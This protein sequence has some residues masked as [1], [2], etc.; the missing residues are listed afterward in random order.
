ML[1]GSPSFSEMTKSL[2]GMF[3][4]TQTTVNLSQKTAE[5]IINP[6]VSVRVTP[7]TKD[8]IFESIGER[9]T[10]KT[11]KPSVAAINSLPPPARGARRVTPRGMNPEI[12]IQSVAKVTDNV[13]GI[14]LGFDDIRQYI[15]TANKA[16][17]DLLKIASPLHRIANRLFGKHRAFCQA[18]D[19][20]TDEYKGVRGRSLAEWVRKSSLVG[21]FYKPAVLIYRQGPGVDLENFL[22][23]KNPQLTGIKDLLVYVSCKENESVAD[24]ETL[25]RVFVVGKANSHG[26][27]FGGSSLMDLAILNQLLSVDVSSDT[28]ISRNSRFCTIQLSENLDT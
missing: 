2:L 25:D 9:T 12:V 10:A 11:I 21:I 18:K 26:G 17:E 14:E 1:R 3:E 15:T 20:S 22:T 27:S 8:E 13:V 16:K 4:T 19:N 28:L 23:R 7:N 5:R 6:K 24:L